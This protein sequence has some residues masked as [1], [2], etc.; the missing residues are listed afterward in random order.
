MYFQFFLILIL[1]IL[2]FNLFKSTI[3]NFENSTFYDYLI[4]GAG[5]AGLQ[6]GFFLKKFNKK[7]LILEKSGSVGNFFKTFP[8]HRKLISINKVNTGSLNQDFN[9]RHDWN[10][11]ISDNKNLLLK[12]QSKDYF[13]S[14]D[15]Y[16]KYLN[17][18]YQQ[19]K[20]NIKFNETVVEINQEN[21]IF[22]IKTSNGLYRSKKL[23]VATGLYK[24]HSLDIDG[25]I[26]Y[27]ELTLDK[28]KFTNKNVLIIGHG[29]S[30]FET[31]D[32]LIDTA[33][34]IHLIGRNPVKFAWQTHYA[35]DLRAINNNFLDTYQLKS[36][37]GI[38]TADMADFKFEK[39]NGK[40]ILYDSQEKVIYDQ[41][42]TEG[43]DYVIDCT[44]FKIDLSVF[45]NIL[46]KNNDRVPI[47]KSNFESD[48]IDNLFFAGTLMQ[49]IS[50]KKSSG[51]FIHG[52]RHLIESMIRLDTN[53]LRI[54]KL[55]SNEQ[56]LEKIL[57][58][59][60]NSPGLFQMFSCLSDVIIIDKSEIS[61]IENIPLKY[62]YEYYIIK[63]TEVIIVYLSYGKDFGGPINYLKNLENST[64]VF[65]QDRSEGTTKDTAHLSNFLHP[66]IEYYKDGN[67]KKNMH[68]AE[69][70]MNEFKTKKTHIDPLDRFINSLV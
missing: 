33:S 31:A 61:Y 44:G 45:G 49:Y 66:L 18:Y 3:E 28:S 32:H 47:I 30:A 53:N 60:N 43:Y 48:N 5:P 68:L 11:L 37:N 57:Y 63:H 38:I 19:N 41:M 6:A 40:Y 54:T 8:I 52:F 39:N 17:D 46:P 51:A 7:Y 21:K 59:V 62:A 25:A 29:N 15:S 55:N 36:Q 64:Y 4:I 27:S 14:A 26:K 69:H 67:L 24:S 56:L 13:P 1:I 22:E 42:P 34:I 9:L 10:S 50:Y 58:Q 16:L 20:I 35:G 23:I 12:N 2:I 70:L 65:G